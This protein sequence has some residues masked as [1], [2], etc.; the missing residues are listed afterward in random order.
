MMLEFLLAKQNLAFTIAY[1]FMLLFGLLTLITGA[2]SGDADVDVDADA[3]IDIDADGPDF[4]A[5][6]LSFLG[7]GKAPVMMLL[8]AFSW[9]FGSAGFILQWIVRG[10]TGSLLPA[11]LAIPAAL[12]PALILHGA[13]A[14]L[15]SKLTN[16][17]DSAAIHSD[18]LVGKTAT[19]V[20]A[21]TERGK[22]TQAK[23]RDQFGTTHYILVEPHRDE[24]R[25]SPGEEVVLVSRNGSLFEAM[26]TDIE[27]ISEHL[28]PSLPKEK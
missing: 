23:V 25:F 27:V 13:V 28:R 22:P 18:A 1:A 9:A 11:A 3:D 14:A 12:V 4:A 19:V 15:L 8:V 24:D 26:P 5:G 21:Q 6:A 16:R 20:L 17:E 7:L 10:S 2:M